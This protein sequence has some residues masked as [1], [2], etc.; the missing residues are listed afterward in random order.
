MKKLDLSSLMSKNKPEEV[1]SEEE[2]ETPVSAMAAFIKAVKSGNAEA[3][4][5]AFASYQILCDTEH[6]DEEPEYDTYSG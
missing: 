6:D 5:T 1:P 3:A 2:S 4:H